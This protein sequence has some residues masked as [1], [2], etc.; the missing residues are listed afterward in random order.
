MEQHLNEERQTSPPFDIKRYFSKLVSNYY[1]FLLTL[2]ICGTTA[3]LYLRYTQPLYEVSTFILVK[4][5]N[6]AMNSTLGGSTFAGGAMGSSGPGGFDPSNEI[7][8]L[9]SEVLLGGVVDS[10]RLDISAVRSGRVR[11]KAVDL[12]ALPFSL[13]VSKASPENYLPM[14]KLLLTESSYSLHS[15]KKIIKGYYGQPLIIGDDTLIITLTSYAPQDLNTEYG[16]SLHKRTS[17]ISQLS[18]RITV[19]PVPKAGAGMLQI[20]VRDE[21]PTRGNKII[22]ALIDKYDHANLSFKNQSLKKE[23]DFLSDRV[24]TVGS[25]L[26]QQENTIRDFKVSNKVND[27]SSSATQLLT[28]LTALDARKS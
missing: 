1:W 28:N 13:S 14:H 9:Q 24:A 11:S 6:D 2:A 19:Q 4:S 7:F 22:G 23:I 20:L 18:M 8:K 26:L 27:F 16:L 5:P 21:L 12:A 15:N 3:F 10:L 25:E 17:A